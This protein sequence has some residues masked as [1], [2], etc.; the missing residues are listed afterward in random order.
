M[1]DS[2]ALDPVSASAAEIAQAVS[3]GEISAAAVVDTALG[4]I[5]RRDGRPEGK[6]DEVDE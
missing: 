3:G 5:G 2:A 1:P 4:E 6:G